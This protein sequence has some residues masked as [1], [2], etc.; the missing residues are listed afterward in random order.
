MMNLVSK[1]SVLFAAKNGMR[2]GVRRRSNLAFDRKYVHPIERQK[3]SRAKA[4]S[5]DAFGSS[6]D[7]VPV[8]AAGLMGDPS[9]FG[10][11]QRKFSGG[12]GL[13]LPFNRAKKWDAK[14]ERDTS[15]PDWE[16][17]AI[18]NGVKS[19]LPQRPTVL[20]AHSAAASVVLDLVDQLGD[21]AQSE[22]S[23]ATLRGAILL[24]P[25]LSTHTA[26][27]FN[28]I[29]AIYEV[30]SSDDAPKTKEEF[31][32]VLVEMGFDVNVVKLIVSVASINEQGRVVLPFDVD[33]MV[34]N[35]TPILKSRHT[36]ERLMH[37][38]HTRPQIT[39]FYGDKGY[40]NSCTGPG[41]DAFKSGSVQSV[42]GSHFLHFSPGNFQGICAAI[43]KYF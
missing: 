36:P 30:L 39:V 41:W 20:I 37:L 27:K 4:V 31:G 32:K 42:K 16:G 23:S 43:A 5:E 17:A 33:F 28:L 38:I 34:Q 9:Q 25:P 21:D 15:V 12:L 29:E 13:N 18:V 26:S 2:A 24:E 22:E 35:R 8:W 10:R 1:Q 40:I 6:A 7:P 19:E 11:F 3:G 14:A